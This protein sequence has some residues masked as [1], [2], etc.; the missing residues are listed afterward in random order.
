MR[1]PRVRYSVLGLM[2]VIAVV[3]AALGGRRM[4]RDR[5]RSLEREAANRAI[6]R[7]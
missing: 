5:L 4:Y 6:A 2:I 7:K 3:G 1:I